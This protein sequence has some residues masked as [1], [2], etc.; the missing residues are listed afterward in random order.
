MKKTVVAFLALVFFSCICGT[1]I[2]KANTIVTKT[3]V[4]KKTIKME[5]K[6]S[7]PSRSLKQSRVRTNNTIY[8]TGR[9]VV[10][11]YHHISNLP[12]SSI[13]I[14]PERFE[15]DLKMLRDK[16]FNIISL[17]DMIRSMNNLGT[18]PDNAVVI[19]FDDGIGSF[20]KYAYPLL[21]KYNMCATN[22]VI[23]VRNEAYKPSTEDTNP[24]SPAQI[25]EMFKS[26]LVDIQSHT[27]DSHALVYINAELKKASKL[28]YRIYNKDTKTLESSADYDKR[29][30]ADLTKSKNLI[31]KY[32]G[33][34]ADV[35]C[36][37]FGTYNDHLIE[38][39]KESGFKYFVTT[40]EGTNR[41]NSDKDLILRI[42]SGDEKLDTEK[43][44]DSILTVANYKKAH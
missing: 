43:L 10:L 14:K 39:A 28:A 41:M 32:T 3:L 1:F 40:R 36:F 6:T 30:I 21:Q 15:S 9:A 35:L 44:Y 16:G 29:V 38:L 42:R 19:T 20:Y 7:T 23:T 2:V 11:T 8:Y 33:Q 13:T 5:N 17:R 26:G 27:N 24:L 34:Y 22:F 18:M 37:P 12:Y 4:I 31:Y 25:T